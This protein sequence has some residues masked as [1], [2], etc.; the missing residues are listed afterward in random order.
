MFD[1]FRQFQALPITFAVEIVRLKVYVI[2]SQ[3]DDLAS[4]QLRLLNV[5]NFK[6]VL[7]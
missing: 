5:T 2:F 4:S 3:S 6:R 7:S 1:Y